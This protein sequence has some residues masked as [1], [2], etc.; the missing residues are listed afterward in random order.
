MRRLSI[1]SECF[2]SCVDVDVEPS[3]SKTLLVEINRSGIEPLVDISKSTHTVKL[4]GPAWKRFVQKRED[5]PDG[6]DPSYLFAIKN[7]DCVAFPSTK[8]DV[9]ESTLHFY[10]AEKKELATASV[11]THAIDIRSNATNQAYKF[12]PP[13]E[14]NLIRELVDLV[15]EVVLDG[16]K[17]VAALPASMAVSWFPAERS[18]WATLPEWMASLFLRF[19]SHKLRI[20]VL[21]SAAAPLVS[22]G[23]AVSTDIFLDSATVEHTTYKDVTSRRCTFRIHDSVGGCVCPNH[24][25]TNKSAGRHWRTAI[26]LSFCGC[27]LDGHRCPLH[28]K[29]APSATDPLVDGICTHGLSV[30]L[31]CFHQDEDRKCTCTT[32][33]SVACND[34]FT[35]L[36]AASCVELT[37][38]PIVVP[39]EQLKQA[40]ETRFEHSIREE[41]AALAADDINIDIRDQIIESVLRSGDYFF[42]KETSHRGATKLA[43]LKRKKSNDDDDDDYDDD[44]PSTGAAASSSSTPRRT[45]AA[46]AAQRQDSAVPKWVCACASTHAHLLPVH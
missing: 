34:K 14:S 6:V 5:R 40:I 31:L 12:T 19:A 39:V 33:M 7:T 9:F 41:I 38:R 37:E 8:W 45:V 4:K 3:V 16:S 21:F 26:Q 32:V 22:D 28:P 1:N 43:V 11:G 36:F 18:K 10:D 42:G 27:K 23:T 35:K 30:K 46:A 2:N 17:S 13:E 44:D 24:T 25:T 15:Q 20:H 29:V